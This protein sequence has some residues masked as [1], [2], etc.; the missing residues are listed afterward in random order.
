MVQI[1]SYKLTNRFWLY[2]VQAIGFGVAITGSMALLGHIF[3]LPVL[4][5]WNA[6]TGMALPTALSFVA[7]G[8]ATF[9]LAFRYENGAAHD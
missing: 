2:L 7:L 9:I 5:S 8:I 3:D 4:Y 1:E 6:G